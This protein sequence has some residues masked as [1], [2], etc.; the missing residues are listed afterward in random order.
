[1]ANRIL[2]DAVVSDEGNVLTTQLDAL[3]D[4]AYSA[5]GAEYDNTADLWQYG[6]LRLAVDFVS[7]PTQP[8][9][10]DIYLHTA[11]DGTNYPTLDSD[12][13]PRGGQLVCTIDLIDT[14]AAQIRDSRM[15]RLPPCKLKFSLRNLAGQAYP[16]SGSTLK[17]YAAADEV[18]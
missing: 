14:T 8:A 9:S 7:A 1:M 15:F 5:A 3:A 6:W 4:T 10:A 16:A 18:Q 13:D 2:W 11:L 17:L 12:N